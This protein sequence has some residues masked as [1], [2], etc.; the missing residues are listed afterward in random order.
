M[1][2]FSVNGAA[3]LLERDRRAVKHALRHIPPDTTVK[4]SPRWRL[5]TIVNALQAYSASHGN[6]N[7]S[8]VSNGGDNS[9][10]DLVNELEAKFEAFE[11]GCERLEREPDITKRRALNDRLGVSHLVG[12]IDTLHDRI[13]EM[14]PGPG[15]DMSRLVFERII[16][17]SM[18][19][20]SMALCEIELDPAEYDR[21]IAENKRRTPI[22]FSRC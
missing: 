14:R 5:A 20:R 11:E 9:Y 4:N 16:M 17:P 6:G 21:I 13:T 15:D 8:S 10:R 1:Q 22:S 2:F 19:E 18:I 12:K 7:R 3:E